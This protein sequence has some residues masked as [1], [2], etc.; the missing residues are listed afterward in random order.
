MNSFFSA[1]IVP[2]FY[3]SIGLI[4]L[5]FPEIPQNDIS[6]EYSNS[7]ISLI[8]TREIGILF[9]IIGFLI[10]KIYLTSISVYRLMNTTFIIVMLLLASIG[11]IM[12]LLLP[13]KPQQL[14]FTTIINLIFVFLYSYERKL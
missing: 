10:R 13:E 1:K 4:F 11:P 7:K 12:Y 8:F 9:I 14:I 5:I 6:S 3:I 2:I